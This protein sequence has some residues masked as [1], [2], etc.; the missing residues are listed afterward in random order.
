MVCFFFYLLKD[1]MV[2]SRIQL[3]LIKLLSLFSFSFCVDACFQTCWANLCGHVFPTDSFI[4]ILTIINEDIFFLSLSLHLHYY[5]WT[6]GDQLLSP[7]Y[8]KLNTWLVFF[9]LFF[10]ILFSSLLLWYSP[11]LPFIFPSSLP[12]LFFSCHVSVLSNWLELAV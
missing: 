3:L 11:F 6:W 7:K 5:L 1:I 8:P 12:F 9:F 2:S 10:L 4:F